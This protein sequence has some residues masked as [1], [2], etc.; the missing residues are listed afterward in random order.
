M[1]WLYTDLVIFS[2]EWPRQKPLS[3]LPLSPNSEHLAPYKH[4]LQLVESI[5]IQGFSSFERITR[6]SHGNPTQLWDSYNTNLL[7]SPVIKASSAQWSEYQTQHFISP[8]LPVTPLCLSLP[9]Y[10][11]PFPPPPSLFP[12][13]SPP[14]PPFLS[15][16]LPPPSRPPPPLST[17]RLSV[18]DYHEDLSCWLPSVSNDF[19]SP[20][21]MQ[22]L[23]QLRWVLLLL[24]C[25]VPED[26]DWVHLAPCP[27]VSQASV[28]YV[29][30]FLPWKS[31]WTQTI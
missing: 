10:L 24:S 9:V 26:S 29:I 15:L 27:S 4:C 2:F 31:F 20:Q 11:P 21:V 28:L 13:L 5:Q 3:T 8:V 16:S 25:S 12:S 19:Y 30:S 23:G 18:P 1:L 17:S 6:Q 22:S 14:L 7:N